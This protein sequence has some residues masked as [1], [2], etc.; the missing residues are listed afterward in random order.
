[1]LKWQKK[2]LCGSST[3]KVNLY[4]TKIFFIVLLFCLS[5]V[6]KSKILHKSICIKNI[7]RIDI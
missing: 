1:M 4:V 3:L 2:L 6:K 5:P 7:F